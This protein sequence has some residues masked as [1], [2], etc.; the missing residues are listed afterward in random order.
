MLED[1]VDDLL[2]FVGAAC[3]RMSVC[4]EPPSL[5]CRGPGHEHKAMLR[6]IA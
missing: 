5:T 4:I 3:S 1:A 6:A 2:G